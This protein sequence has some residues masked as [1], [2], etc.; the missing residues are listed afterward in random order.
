[1]GKFRDI[2][3]EAEVILKGKRKVTKDVPTDSRGKPLSVSMQ[4]IM[5]ATKELESSSGFKHRNALSSVLD[6][7]KAF[8]SAVQKL[9][10]NN[11]GYNSVKYKVRNNF[12]QAISS[13]S[14]M[15]TNIKKKGLKAVESNSE[16]ME[17]WESLEIYCKNI[18]KYLKK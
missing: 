17:Q 11:N 7:L 10:K 9:P 12:E 14:N 18:T 3:D 6:A 16:E 8:Q 13:L 2:L 15:V 1:M 5:K 4:R